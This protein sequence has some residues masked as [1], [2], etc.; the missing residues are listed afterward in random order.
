ML[1]RPHEVP[2][3]DVI[4]DRERLVEDDGE[5]G[6]KVVEGEHDECGPDTEPNEE[7]D[8]TERR[9]DP[10]VALKLLPCPSFEDIVDH[11]VGPK[12]PLY[13]KTQHQDRREGVVDLGRQS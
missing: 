13:Q 3:L 2:H 1:Y 8:R 9:G 7:A 12:R 5:G 4:S 6:E 10:G 11:P